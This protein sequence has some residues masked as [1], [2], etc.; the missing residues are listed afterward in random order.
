MENCADVAVV[1]TELYGIA[2]EGEYLIR[3]IVEKEGA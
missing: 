3:K 2:L 1:G